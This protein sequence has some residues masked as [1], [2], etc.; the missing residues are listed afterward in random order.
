MAHDTTC[1]ECG[2]DRSL[3]RE[4][5]VE[6]VENALHTAEYEQSKLRCRVTELEQVIKAFVTGKVTVQTLRA[7]ADP[8]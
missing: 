3:A 6:R 4:R 8:A 1:I 7:V 2:L 5:A